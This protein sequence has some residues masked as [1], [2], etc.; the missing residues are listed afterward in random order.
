MSKL[1]IVEKVNMDLKKVDERLSISYENE[2]YSGQDMEE[3]GIQDINETRHY[4]LLLATSSHSAVIIKEYF[5]FDT[6]RSLRFGRNDFDYL[7][8]QDF[9]RESILAIENVLLSHKK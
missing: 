9:T 2:D 8:N 5:D 3:Y 6:P 1:A 7:K 4:S